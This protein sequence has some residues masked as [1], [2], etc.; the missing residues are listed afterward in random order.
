MM[1]II[2]QITAKYS[3]LT[4]KVDIA[5]SLQYCINLIYFFK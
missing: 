1:K 2:M 5:L 3:L 4:D